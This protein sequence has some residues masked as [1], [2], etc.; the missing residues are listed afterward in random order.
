M[1]NNNQEIYLNPIIVFTVD[2]LATI[3]LGDLVSQLQHT[4]QYLWN[5]VA[6][7]ML[8]YSALLIAF[9][10]ILFDHEDWIESISNNVFE[11]FLFTFSYFSI[12]F[13]HSLPFV[14]YL[15]TL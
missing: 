4:P 3:K 7:E 9:N 13:V 12:L 1:N 5:K 6:L 8:L 2:I 11:H 15:I 10:L 14:F